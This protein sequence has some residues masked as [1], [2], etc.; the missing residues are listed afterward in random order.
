MGL[1]RMY[2]R[3]SMIARIAIEI[4]L[5]LQRQWYNHRRVKHTKMRHFKRQQ[6]QSGNEAHEFF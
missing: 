3:M 4:V 2:R 5:E 1:E 6:K